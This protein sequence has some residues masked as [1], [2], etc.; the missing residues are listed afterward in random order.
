MLGS[1][2][3]IGINWVDCCTDLRRRRDWKVGRDW[4]RYNGANVHTYEYMYINSTD[5]HTYM[6]L[7]SDLISPPIASPSSFITSVIGYRLCIVPQTSSTV[8]P[9][10]T[11]TL[12]D[13]KSESLP[14]IL[15][16]QRDKLLMQDLYTWDTD[17]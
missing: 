12:D 13:R 11:F 17:V 3:C 1:R 5:I 14:D 8:E 15:K 4:D 2:G 10:Y 16:R 7:H 6:H 9:R